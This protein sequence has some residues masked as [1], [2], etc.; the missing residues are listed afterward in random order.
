MEPVRTGILSISE[1]FL[2]P[3]N[4]NTRAIFFQGP[5]GRKIRN[6][7]RIKRSFVQMSCAMSLVCPSIATHCTC[8]FW[9]R[10]EP[11]NMP[12]SIE[13]PT[14]CGVCSVIWFLYSEKVMRNVVLRYCSYSWR[15]SASLCSCNKEASEAFSMR[16][17]L[18]THH[19]L[20]RLGSLW[21]SS[22]SSCETVIGEQHFGTM[23]CRPAYRIGWKHRRLASMTRVLESW[24]HATKNVYIWALTI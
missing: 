17:C 2:G 19:H 10:S 24:Y 3:V 5:I 15:C 11:V 4:Y 16:K 18:I 12:K 22:L 14:K 8:Q 7:V 13:S 1:N 23:S 6:T 9:V 21:F 20:P